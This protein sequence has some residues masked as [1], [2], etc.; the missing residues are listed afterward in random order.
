MSDL[1]GTPKNGFLAGWLIYHVGFLFIISGMA[2]QIILYVDMVMSGCC[3]QF[4]GLLP[5]IR[6]S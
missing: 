2:K 3:F 5:N 6:M 1:V 4:M